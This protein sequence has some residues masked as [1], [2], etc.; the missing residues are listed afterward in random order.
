MLKLSRCRNGGE[1]E[2]SRRKDGLRNDVNGAHFIKMCSKIFQNVFQA[3]SKRLL[4]PLLSQVSF[5]MLPR[6][7][8][9]KKYEKMKKPEALFH[10]KNKANQ[11]FYL[12]KPSQTKKI[13]C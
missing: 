12:Q 13:T 8:I 11:K 1:M 9:W 4:E 3:S 7:K 10:V 5:L 6:V 2:I